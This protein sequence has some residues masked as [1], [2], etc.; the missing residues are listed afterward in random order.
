MNP[1]AWHLLGYISNE[2]PSAIFKVSGLSNTPH[3][4]ADGSNFMFGQ[5]SCSILAQ[6]GIAVDSLASIQQ[7]CPTTLQTTDMLST[8]VALQFV[9]KMLE[10]LFNYATSFAVTQSQMTPN[11]TETFVPLSS[12]QS[13]YKN[14]ERKLSSPEFLREFS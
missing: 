7:Q 11:P 4:N 1:P 2:K 14:F 13:W 12:L 8:P 9:Q 10:N 6:I 5:V 3:L